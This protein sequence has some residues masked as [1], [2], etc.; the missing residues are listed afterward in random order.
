MVPLIR[1][2]RSELN[3]NPDAHDDLAV[4]EV[5]AHEHIRPVNLT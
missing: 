2:V 1:T 5:A 4:Y 3:P